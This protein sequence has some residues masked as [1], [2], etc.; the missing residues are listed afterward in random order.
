MKIVAVDCGRSRVKVV[1]EGQKPFMFPSVLGQYH[2]RG[3][4]EDL[5]GDIEMFYN[6]SGYFIGQLAERE[7]YNPYRNFD[8]TKVTKETLLLTLAALWQTGI[9]DD[10]FL[11]M[12]IPI[13]NYEDEEERRGLKELLKG[14]HEVT[15]NG[16]T[17]TIHIARV[18]IVMEGA[19]A[20]FAHHRLGTVRILD[21]G[22]RM[23]NAA[24]FKDGVYI[25]RESGS[26]NLGCDMLGKDTKV[27]EEQIQT[28]ADTIN[29]EVRRLRWEDDD[30]VLLIGGGNEAFAPYIQNYFP[31]A[32][33]VKDGVYAN[34][35]GCLAAGKARRS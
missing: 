11:V 33:V 7:A 35:L 13:K 5:P 23:W 8:R 4:R 17:R 26:F 15:V 16:D 22:S 28:A 10:I 18:M 20:F 34:V 21:L 12:P 25:N 2:K 32:E 14:E 1:A 27:T 3:Y 6:G 30:L 29:G 31:N 24:T 9:Q 19:V